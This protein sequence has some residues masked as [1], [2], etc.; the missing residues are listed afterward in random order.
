[1]Q[2]DRGGKRL[3]RKEI[4]EKNSLTVRK[5]AVECAASVETKG[6]IETLFNN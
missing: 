5:A 6:L 2:I 4:F 3:S 1:M